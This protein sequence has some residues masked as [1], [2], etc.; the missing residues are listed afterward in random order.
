M[1]PFKVLEGTS[2][3]F[4]ETVVSHPTL[5]EAVKHSALVAE[6]TALEI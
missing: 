2:H 3:E 6:G 4:E 5:S 1:T